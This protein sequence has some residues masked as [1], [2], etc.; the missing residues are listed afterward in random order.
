MNRTLTS[1]L[2]AAGLLIAA[3]FPVLAHHSFSAEFD[4]NKPV[5][6]EGTVAKMEWSNPHTWLFIDVKNA[7]GK[8]EQW[9]VEGGA[10]GVLL[11]NGWNRN[12]LPP[13]TRIVVNGHVAKDG[14]LRANSSSIELPDGRK[15]DTGSS[16]GKE[17]A[18]K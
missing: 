15:L 17:D 7:E 8:V 11:R 4:A 16:Y 2:G 18:K 9:A 13:G 6:L 14:S 10:P 3:A 1:T 12:S 5:R